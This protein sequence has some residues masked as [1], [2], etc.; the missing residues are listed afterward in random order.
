MRKKLQEEVFPTKLFQIQ[1]DKSKVSLFIRDQ[2]YSDAWKISTDF[3][4]KCKGSDSR[5]VALRKSHWEAK[6]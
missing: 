6:G 5:Q 1:P 2:W 3:D 4:E